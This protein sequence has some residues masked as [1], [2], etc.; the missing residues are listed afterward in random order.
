MN[1]W[2][3]GTEGCLEAGKKTK[4]SVEGLEVQDDL[5]V[6]IKQGLPV[7]S[8][9]L[10]G[11]YIPAVSRQLRLEVGIEDPVMFYIQDNPVLYQDYMHKLLQRDMR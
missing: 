6:A 7:Q 1:T 3:D 4:A 9:A 5:E 10:T 8:P 2:R 11:G